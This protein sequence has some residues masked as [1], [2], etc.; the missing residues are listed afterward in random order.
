MRARSAVCVRVCVGR[1]W[2]VRSLRSRLESHTLYVKALSS[3]QLNVSWDP[4]VA[5]AQFLFTHIETGS[6]GLTRRV[7]SR[8]LRR[9]TTIL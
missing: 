7:V 8:P 6:V 3:G 9:G 4:S 5:V 2:R 1:A